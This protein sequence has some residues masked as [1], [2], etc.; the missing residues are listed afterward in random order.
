MGL[1]MLD[2]AIGRASGQRSMVDTRIFGASWDGGSSPAL[3]RT[4]DAVGKTAAAG[5]DSGFV[6]N[7]FDKLPIFKDMV[8][9]RDR[10]GNVFVRIPKFYWSL[11]ANGATRTWAISLWKHSGFELPKCFWDAT[12][13]RELP[14][15]LVGKYKAALSADT[16]KLES[17]PGKSPLVNKN[18]VEFRNY[19]TANNANGQSGY[20]Q[21]DLTTYAVLRTL[22]RIE[23]ATLNIQSIAQGY[24]T[25]QWSASHLATVAGTGVNQIVVANAT[26]S[27]YAVGQCIDIDTAAGTM[28]DRAIAKDRLITAINVYDA[29]N[30]ALVFDGATVNIAIGNV[31]RN[32][33]QRTGSADAVTAT[34]GS[35]ASNADGKRPFVYRGIESLFGDLW[36]WVDGVN[37][38]ERQAWV[39]DNPTQY[40]SNVFASPY[41]QLA[42]PN[43]AADG[44]AV[45]MGYDVTHP[46]AE[47]ATGVAGGSSSTYYSDYYYQTTGQRVARVGGRWDSG[48]GCGPVFWSLV[49]SAADAGVS[50]G[51]RLV[52][53]PI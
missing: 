1:K 21:L 51:G 30:K 35:V 13:Q 43:G 29:S 4:H 20:Q 53:R 25:G 50:F 15:I 24:S 23:F 36:Q 47:F 18:I 42:Y 17:K 10:Y 26:A 28:G 34:S 8:E 7:D 33:G 12:N 32:C 19:A 48:A 16:T 46:E 38:N 14:Y 22:M 27:A 49:S 39:C 11:T 31:V 45:T 3:T 37:I 40:A 44:Y 2:V 5:V 41:Q 9:E 52:K 6:A